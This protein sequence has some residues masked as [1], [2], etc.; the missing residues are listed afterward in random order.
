MMNRRKSRR[1]VCSF[2]VLLFILLGWQ[3]VS[4]VAGDETADTLSGAGLRTQYP[5]FFHVDSLKMIIQK[6]IELTFTDRFAKAESLYAAVSDAYRSSP[7]GPMFAA[8]TV[9]AQM[10]DS[11]SPQRRGD[12]LRWLNMSKERAERWR[13]AEPRNGE[14]EFVL[15]AALGYQAVYE[16]R[17][18]GWFA[19]LKQGLRS[20]NRFAAALKKDSSLADAFLGIGN[21]NYW[22]S[23][24]TDFINW[25]GIISD[26]R[27]EGLAQLQKAAAGGT[28][29]RAPARVSLAWALINEGRNEEALAHGDTLATEFPG[30]KGPLWIMALAGFGLYRW[31]QSRNLY[32][33]LERRLLAEG[34]GNYFNLIDCAYFGALCNYCMGHWRETLDDCHRGLA[35]P[36]PP[37]ILERQKS[38]LKKLRDLQ[39]EVKRKTGLEVTGQR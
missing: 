29:T 34:P 22:K 37:D 19:A 16:S 18:G 20:K 27:E 15:G 32:A 8:A 23:A 17:W 1:L 24:S 28:L 12:F 11:E 31:E 4:A 25:T 14:P 3:F 36:A 9:H 5:S 21:F 26:D 6:G 30:G 10:L 7:I 13:A 2:A 39:S 33:E 35:Y 38:K